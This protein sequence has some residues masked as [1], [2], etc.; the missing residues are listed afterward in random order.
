VSNKQLEAAL[1]VLETVECTSGKIAKREALERAKKNKVLQTILRM[2]LDRSTFG[3][4]PSSLDSYDKVTLSLKA[5][6]LKT[7]DDSWSA[8][9]TLAKQLASRKLSGNAAKTALSD[10]L[11]SVKNKCARK[12][13]HR[14]FAKNLR[15][16]IDHTVSDV[17]PGLVIRWG[18]PK[19]KSLVDQTAHKMDKKLKEAVLAALPK[20]IRSQ[21]KCDGV[22][23]VAVCDTGAMHSSSGDLS[24]AISKYAAAIAEAVSTLELPASFDGYTPLIS[25]ECEAKYDPKKDTAWDSPWGKGGAIARFGRT[26]TGF[27]PTR[28]TPDKQKL[29][30][31]DFIFVIYDI[32]PDIAQQ[33]PVV[34]K[35]SIRRAL[36]SAIAYYCDTHAKK[37]GIRKGSISLIPE[38]KCHTWKALEDQHAEWLRRG[39]EGSI[40]RLPGMQTLADSKTRNI[41]TNFLKWKQ[42]DYVDAVI[43]GVVA[44]KQNTKNAER[45]GSFL[46]W[47]P[48]KKTTSK[49]TIPTDAGKDLALKNA[50]SFVGYMLE[51][52]QQK[53]AG[54]DVAKSRFPTLSRFRD[55]LPPLSEQEV[56]K[57]CR[58]AHM[59]VTV[60]RKKSSDKQAVLAMAA[61]CN[62]S[63]RSSKKLKD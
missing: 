36:L 55:D 30:D 15:C 18:V 7:L 37:L 32:Y 43:L 24:P 56:Q 19:G 41:K 50:S 13:F 1:Q 14:V 2:S 51:A 12:W 40:L 34:I 38:V 17:W 42:Y 31:N 57:I 25:G 23:G 8:F 22:H 9:Q 3:I 27:D 16:G 35:H 60:S 33:Q 26:G 53:D 6:N 4:K 11:G 29:V 61:A 5:S 21:P 58:Q 63:T 54:G 48:A 49:V 44:G 47:L 39:Y 45:G 62:A 10:F 59:S 28:I 52:S 46:V 20:G